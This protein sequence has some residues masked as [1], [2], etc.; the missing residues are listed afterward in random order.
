MSDTSFVKHRWRLLLNLAT[1]AALF[2]LAIVIRH[3]IV[4]TFENLNKVKIWVLLFIIPIEII[5]YHAQTKV[6]QKLLAIL[7]ER[8][9]YKNLFKLSLELNF[10][11]HVFPSGGVSGI[12]YF[13]FRMRNFGVRGTRSTLIQTMK[14]MLLFLSFEPVLLAGM[15]I[16]AVR[17]HANDFVIFMGSALTTLVIFVTV[18]FIYIIGNQVRINSF[19]TP[20]VVLV[21]RLIYAV[22][23]KHPEMINIV[24]TREL[25]QDFHA[26]YSILQEHYFELKEPFLW[27][28]LAN[29]AEVSV[30]YVV[31]IAFGANAGVDVGAIILAYAVANFAG[32][33][34][35]FPGGTGVYE[36]LMTLVLVA[37]GIPAR[38]SLPV[39]IMYRIL[40]TLLQIPPGY[41]LYH[42]TLKAGY[43]KK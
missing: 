33:I 3:Q 6:Y 15:L 10:V 5:D 30:I 36:A 27:S 14:L 7:G 39:T 22:R 11:N 8:L 23:P 35:V 4:E 31:Y 1:I 42:R 29:I 28:M 2:V 26:N 40:N 16:L 20:L 34:S 43:P 32:L 13:G 9:S 21:N 24:N 17:G 38:I 37:T 25:F 41:F 18:L 19:L 12:S